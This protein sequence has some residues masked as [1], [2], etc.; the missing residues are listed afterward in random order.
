ME[1]LPGSISLPADAKVSGCFAHQAK[2]SCE[3]IARASC[4]VLA[5]RT[6]CALV[7]ATAARI[8]T[9]QRRTA[10]AGKRQRRRRDLTAQEEVTEAES[11]TRRRTHVAAAGSKFDRRNAIG[12]RKGFSMPGNMAAMSLGAMN[13]QVKGHVTVQRTLRKKY[14]TD[15]LQVINGTA[16][17]VRGLLS[18][19]QFGL[20]ARET[21]YP[22]VRDFISQSWILMASRVE[23]DDALQEVARDL[24][25]FLASSPEDHA[26]ASFREVLLEWSRGTT[27]AAPQRQKSRKLDEW[28]QKLGKRLD[29]LECKIIKRIAAEQ[30]LKKLQKHVSGSRC[31]LKRMTPAMLTKVLVA[32]AESSPCLQLQ[33]ADFF[34]RY[35][36][37]LMEI[38]TSLIEEHCIWNYLKDAPPL[39]RVAFLQQLGQHGR[40]AWASV[41]ADEEAVARTLGD[42]AVYLV[43]RQPK[44][45]RPEKDSCATMEGRVLPLLQMLGVDRLAEMT[46]SPGQEV[47]S[48]KQALALCEML[49]A[50]LEAASEPLAAVAALD[51][52]KYVEEDV[53]TLAELLPEES[54]LW[55]V[56]AASMLESWSR[57]HYT[58]LLDS[59]L[60]L[61][62]LLSQA[63][64]LATAL[65]ARCYEQ[66]MTVLAKLPYDCFSWLVQSW[67]GADEPIMGL[68]LG[69]AV[70]RY[71]TRG[72]LR[73]P[74]FLAAS[75]LLEASHSGSLAISCW[76]AWAEH[77]VDEC[78]WKPWRWHVLQEALRE[79]VAWR[80]EATTVSQELTSS[81]DVILEAVLVPQLC[82]AS[83]ELP[84]ELFMA[85]GK[86]LQC[87]NAEEVRPHFEA[88]VMRCLKGRGGGIS[89]LQSI[90]VASGNTIAECQEGGDLWEALACHAAGK[91]RS[92]KELELFHC[93]AP[94][95]SFQRAVLEKM[96]GWQRYELLLMLGLL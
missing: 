12:S 18:V 33:C 78:K 86:H 84:L 14:G 80:C 5:Q 36:F 63:P 42:A 57:K 41:H 4:G 87:S 22:E 35:I 91:L 23:G 89:L 25:Q 30:S 15:V 43:E 38:N 16:L 74:V 67:A 77:M 65:E 17:G 8:V 46:S 52:A 27:V 64:A 51:A 72:E 28:G 44:R 73:V 6:S 31:G 60:V 3:P 79:V 88:L 45:A 56:L 83:A 1:V 24:G 50:H 10:R 66:E 32:I 21:T 9:S 94:P 62:N 39:L 55:D 71:A 59:M 54:A 37:H 81:A 49:G 75:K 82:S 40:V 34:C 90:A 69:P 47:L 13:S 48:S 20:S 70:E 7:T 29:E 93:S 95:T 58:Q 96:K 26:Q 85:L 68:L 92:V 2:L 19:K 61:P 76:Q 11:L 53:L